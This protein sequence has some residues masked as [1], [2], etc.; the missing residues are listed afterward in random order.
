VEEEEEMRCD[1]NIHHVNGCIN[2]IY[3]WDEKTVN[4]QK[5]G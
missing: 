1:A 5:A 2:V 3:K 4:V